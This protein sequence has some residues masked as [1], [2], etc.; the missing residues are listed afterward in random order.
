MQKASDDV[1]NIH[2][3]FSLTLINPSSHYFSLISSLIVAV[4]IT[5]TTY[6]GYFGSED[7]WFRIP[8]VVMVLAITQLLDTRFTKKKEYSKSLH[9]SL[10]ANLL[11]IATLLMGLLASFVLSKETSLFFITFG[12]FLCAS[13]RIGVFTTTLGVSIKKIWAICLIQPLAMFLIL[14]PQDMWI[15]MLTNPMSLGY[16]IAFLIIA[17]VWSLLT[18]KAGR[19]GMEST[20]KTIQAYL[21]SQK[22]DF[23]DAE[24]LME[25][26]S[27]KTKVSTS[28]IR[29]LSSNGNTEF[30]MILPE[31]HPGPYHPVGGSNIPYLIYKNFNSSAM[32]LHSISDHSLNLPSKN[33]VE[34][35]LENL[36]NST[37]KDEGLVCTEPVTVQIN[38]A[39]V[40]GLLFGKNP[41]LFL[42]LSPH[43]MEDIPC[44]MKTEI[45]QYAKN[46][47]YTRTMIID[48]H[49]AMGSEISKE[50]G[51]DMLKAAK[52]CLDS[53]ITKEN[54]PIEFGYS[55]SNDMDVWTE[56]LGM[57]GLG[58]ICLKINDKK[59]FIGWA[60]ANN[61]ENGVR[62]KIV[63]NFAKRDYNLL[64]ICTSDTHYA[65]VKARNRN[66]YY[67][68]GLI[69]DS[70]K[71]SKWF[72][73]IAEIAQ[74]KTTTAKYEI[75]ENQADVKIMGQGIF[76]DFSKALDNSLKISKI[77]MIGGVCLF[78]TSLFL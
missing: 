59:Y 54:Y 41:V 21:A 77:F 40:T 50:D 25:K 65:P 2:N 72:L 23:T 68:L 30:R 51:E 70:E 35:Y 22:N 43:G 48:S 60:D 8:L 32:V 27:S 61:M 28:Q 71:L 9:V 38:K 73:D 75:L 36:K 55:N 16:G 7:F 1:S 57:G 24:E 52:S 67:Q 3:R 58:I 76:E 18:D 34:N 44:Y 45:E 11:W 20:H 17:S 53:L 19:P 56:D 26:R 10:F 13:I 63:K 6:L 5:V 46:R 12:M 31:I 29:L 66:G 62:E 4:A 42:S 37:V 14:I 39:R 74:I 33:E 64:E 49:N 47:D 78:I 15:S 69:T